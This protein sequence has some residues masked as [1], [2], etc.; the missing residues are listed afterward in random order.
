MVKFKVKRDT[1]GGT[2]YLYN[3]CHYV[4]DWEQIVTIGGFGVDPYNLK[5]TFHQMMC[6]R[7]HF[8]KVSGNPLMHFIVSFD[9]CAHKDDDTCMLAY[10]IT[11]YFKMDY[12]AVWCVHAKKRSCSRYHVHI[13]INSVSYV[14]GKMYNSSPQVIIEFCKNVTKVT[15]VNCGFYFG[16]TA[17]SDDA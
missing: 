14:N 6:V 9:E 15:G 2:Q 1:Y 11:S 17:S 5:K 13:V 12:Q 4:E 3:A 7:E 8:G 16:G 10:K